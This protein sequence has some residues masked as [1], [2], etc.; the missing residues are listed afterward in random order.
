MKLS[1]HYFLFCTLSLALL[2]PFQAEAILL[3]PEDFGA[4]IDDGLP[5]DEAFQA[6]FDAIP[7][8]E[9]NVVIELMPGD[10]S[11]ILFGTLRQRIQNDM[12]EQLDRK[13]HAMDESADS[14]AD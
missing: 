5:D 7:K 8:K 4:V 14:I 2:S 9:L 3:K 11:S 6:M 1:M 12:A 13:H 10:H